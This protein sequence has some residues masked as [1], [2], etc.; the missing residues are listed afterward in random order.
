[1][2]NYC[3][4]AKNYYTL[5]REDDEY[6][7]SRFVSIPDINIQTRMTQIKL[8]HVDDKNTTAND[9]KITPSAAA[10]PVRKVRAGI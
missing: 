2:K 1:M 8:L 4:L 9:Y 5:N 7:Q 3:P 6:L 10:P